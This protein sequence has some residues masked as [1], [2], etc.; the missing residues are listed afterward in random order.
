MAWIGSHFWPVLFGT[1]TWL[2]GQQSRVL[3]HKEAVCITLFLWL[4]W[5]AC[6]LPTWDMSGW[7]TGRSPSFSSVAQGKC[8]DIIAQNTMLA[9]FD[10]IPNSLVMND[11]IIWLYCNLRNREELLDE[12]QKISSLVL[13]LRV[14]KYL[15][16]T[17]SLEVYIVALFSLPIPASCVFRIYLSI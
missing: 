16:V 7:N 14:A 6:F 15:C 1:L 3:Y 13:Y 4:Q 11:L 2:S 5:L 10:I 8:Q 17:F 12:S 9:S